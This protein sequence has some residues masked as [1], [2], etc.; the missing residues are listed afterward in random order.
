MILFC[1]FNFFHPL[2]LTS[3]S[4]TSFVSYLCCLF[5]HL[6]L[7]KFLD[8][9]C[10]PHLLSIPPH[11]ALPLNICLQINVSS[12]EASKLKDEQKLWKNPKVWMSNIVQPFYLSCILPDPKITL[13]T[14]PENS[15]SLSEKKIKSELQVL[16]IHFSCFAF[17]CSILMSVNIP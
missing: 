7:S 1:Y 9:I 6:Q 10:G 3:I 4:A 11:K 17:Q 2:T 13:F 12:A 5:I 15:L 14:V 16:Q 8:L